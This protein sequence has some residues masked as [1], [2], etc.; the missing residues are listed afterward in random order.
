MDK[1][2]IYVFVLLILSLVVTATL[3]LKL[4]KNANNQ[5]FKERTLIVI[6]EAKVDNNSIKVQYTLCQ[7]T[8]TKT[9]IEACLLEDGHCYYYYPSDGDIRA[10]DVPVKD[11]DFIN[12]LDA[13]KIQPGDTTT[14]NME[15]LEEEIRKKF[16]YLLREGGEGE[17]GG[18]GGGPAEVVY[19]TGGLVNPT[20]DFV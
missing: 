14:I 9:E 17:G 3:V 13:L 7:W 18:G 2:N 5:E 4:T 15:D 8:K 12:L 1:S 11:E 6:N 10:G 20:P 19:S 16:V